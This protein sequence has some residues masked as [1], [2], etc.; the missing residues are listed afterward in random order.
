MYGNV[1]I[2]DKDK[3]KENWLSPM[4]KAP[5][6]IEMSKG[7]RDNNKNATKM[8]DYT[9]MLTDLGRLVGVVIATQLVWLTGVRA[10]SSHSP[11]QPCNQ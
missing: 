3:R 6:P 9:T 10:Q 2:Q 7:Q 4:T 5:T 8:F 11:Q 1:F